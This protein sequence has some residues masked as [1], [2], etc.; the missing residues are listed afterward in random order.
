M[1][2]VGRRSRVLTEEEFPGYHVGAQP[3]RRRRRG[4]RADVLRL[5]RAD[6]GSCREHSHKLGNHT[7]D[8][9]F[10]IAGDVSP[11]DFPS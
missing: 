2:S 11:A 4:H 3:R 8:E 7:L 9:L 6:R 1:P 10:E 5:R